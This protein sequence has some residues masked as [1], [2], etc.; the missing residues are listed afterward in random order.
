M[1][2][3][4]AMIDQAKGH[5]VY[6]ATLPAISPDR[7]GFDAEHIAALNEGIRALAA[8][9]GITVIDLDRLLP[10]TDGIHLAPEGYIFWRKQISAARTTR[11]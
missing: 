1:A 3:Y 6:I 4:A 5:D 8:E 11:S 9:K 7:P 2:T 10:T